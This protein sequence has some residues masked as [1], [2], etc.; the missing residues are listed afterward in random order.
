MLTRYLSTT[1]LATITSTSAM[2]ATTTIQIDLT[3][4]IPNVI[5]NAIFAD[6]EGDDW[7]DAALQIDLTAG[8]I[9]NAPAFD[10]DGTQ[11][12][13]WGLV[14]GLQWDSAVGIANDG[15]GGGRWCAG[16]E[17]P[18]PPQNLGGTGVGAAQIGWF[19]TVTT[20]TAPVQIANISLTDDAAGVWSLIT[21]FANGQTLS[22]GSVIN[23]VMVPEPGTMALLGLATVCLIRR[24]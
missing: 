7:I 12:N 20:D 24:R 17:C 21:S 2:A 3:N 18:F 4:T 22:S 15:S 1:L 5:A 19:N 8:S 9:Y 6:G 23:G 14:A 10:A 11:A 13:L 16:S